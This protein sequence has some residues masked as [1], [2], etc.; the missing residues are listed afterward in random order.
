MLL[1][2]WCWCWYQ[3]QQ[4]TTAQSTPSA[5]PTTTAAMTTMAQTFVFWAKY[6]NIF[7]IKDGVLFGPRVVL[8]QSGEQNVP[9]K[10]WPWTEK[11]VAGI[12]ELLTGVGVH[13]KIGLFVASQPPPVNCSQN[14]LVVL[15]TLNTTTKTTT[16]TTTQMGLTPDVLCHPTRPGRNIQCKCQSICLYSIIESA[17]TTTTGALVSSMDILRVGFITDISN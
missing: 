4:L 9:P 8:N 16:T 11:W 10:S 6:N 5:E 2:L 13:N 17:I 14:F 12:N 15:N 7:K 1:C 3:I